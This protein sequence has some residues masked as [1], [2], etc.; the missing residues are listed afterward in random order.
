[1]TC[2]QS[3]YDRQLSKI[4]SIVQESVGV[5]TKP[6]KFITKMLPTL[7]HSMS[8]AFGVSKECYGG[9]GYPLEGAGQGNVVSVS[10]FRDSSCATLRETEKENLVVFITSPLTEEIMQQLEISLVDDNDFASDG[11]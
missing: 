9:T 11:K 6:I 2:L 5:E 4:E 3:F 1:M 7:E 8:T 10:A